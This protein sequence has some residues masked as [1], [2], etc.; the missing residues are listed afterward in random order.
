M[1][2]LNAKNADASRNFLSASLKSLDQAQVE[3]ICKL[4]F[5]LSRL[6]VGAKE[7]ADTNVEG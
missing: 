7:C 2:S 1:K 5:S 6:T 4:N 3:L